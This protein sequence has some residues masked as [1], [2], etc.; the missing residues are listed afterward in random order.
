MMKRVCA[1]CQIVME[2]PIGDTGQVTHGIC[3]RCHDDFI[4]KLGAASGD[5]RDQVGNAAKIS[6]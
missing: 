1:W 5:H 2:C 4:A 6:N 3:L